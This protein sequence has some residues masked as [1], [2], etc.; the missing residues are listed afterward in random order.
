M[1]RKMIP[2]S[3]IE[4]TTIFEILRW[5]AI[6]QSERH[7]YSFLT[8][9]ETKEVRWTYEELDRRA[10]AIGAELQSLKADGKTILLLYS[11]GLE[12]IAGFFGCLYAGAIAV[13]A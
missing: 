9:G 8:D 5:R 6:N 7:A 2:N 13:P 11:P 4:A 3:F 12:Y 10:R 1:R